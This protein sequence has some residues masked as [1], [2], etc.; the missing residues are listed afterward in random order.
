MQDQSVITDE[1]TALAITLTGSDPDDDDLTYAVADGPLNGSLTGTAP[2]LTYTPVLNF[3]GS[4]SFTFRVNDGTVDSSIATVSITIDPV[5]DLPVADD[6]SA[7]TDEDISLEITLTGSDLDGDDLSY[8]VVVAPSNGSLTGSAP[9]ITYT[10]DPHFNGSDNFTFKA[11]DGSADSNTA[12]VSI[13]INPVNDPPEITS[14]PVTTAD[15]E[16][17]YTYDVEAFDSDAG[18]VLTY[19]LTTAPANMTIGHAAGLI[20]WTP[21]TG[22]WH[23]LLFQQKSTFSN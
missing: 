2:A 5:N 6:Q 14:T 11:N 17:P 9:N 7:T 1:D 19:S 22:Q 18:D 12:S 21:P 23:S 3:N 20:Q 4:D 15:E 8:V 13:T 16:T 10:L